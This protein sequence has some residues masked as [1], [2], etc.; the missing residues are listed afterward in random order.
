MVNEQGTTLL[1]HVRRLMSQQEALQLSDHALLER[2][3]TDRDEAAFRALVERHGPMVLRVCR[4]VLHDA[5]AAED[6]FQTTFLV[7]VRRAAS[8]STRDLLPNWLFGVAYRVAR[9]VR[10]EAAKR[11]GHAAPLERRDSAEPPSE[12]AARE[13]CAI[14]DEE[15]HRLPGRYRAAFLLCYVEGRTRDQAACQLG[16][17]VRS[18]HRQLERG[19]NLLRARLTRRGVTLSAALLAQALARGTTAAPVQS[20]LASTTVRAALAA[21]AGASAPAAADLTPVVEGVLAAMPAVKAKA[22]KVFLLAL[23]VLAAGVSWLVRPGSPAGHPQG[24]REAGGLALERWKPAG[25]VPPQADRHGDPLPPG[26]LAR[27]GTA[28]FRQGSP[29]SALSLS[30]DGKLLASVGGYATVHLWDAATGREVRHFAA[31]GRA[32]PLH[33]VTFA[34]GGRTLAACGEFGAALW[35]VATGRLVHPLGAR[36]AA[37]VA[38]SPDGAVVATGGGAG[39]VDLWDAAKGKH[40]GSLQGHQTLG[41]RLGVKALA[42]SP[43]GR[44]LA[45]G[46]HDRQIILWDVAARRQRRGFRGHGRAVTCVAFSLDGKVLSS[47]GEDRTICLWD[48]A[49]GTAL[50]RLKGHQGAVRSLAFAPGGKLLA[51]ASGDF[52]GKREDGAL[53]V[54]DVGTGREVGRPRV[55]PGGVA[56]VAFT[57]DGRTLISACGP[58]IRLWDVVTGQ[59]LNPSRGHRQGIHAVAFSPGGKV[60]ATGGMDGTIRVWHAATGAEQRE[61][62]VGRNAAVDALAFA[63]GGKVLASGSRDGAI[64][65]WDPASGAELKCLVGH[66][67]E[68]T[69]A[70]A[71]DGKVLA[72]GGRGGTILLWDAATGKEIRQLEGAEERVKSLAFSPDGKM[73]ASA[74]LRESFGEGAASDLP[75][76]LWDVATGRE[77]RRLRGH[78]GVYVTAVAFSPDGR[79]LASAGWDRTIR[80]W[81]VVSGKELYRFQDNRVPVNALAFSRDG[82]SLASCGIGDVCLWEVATGQPRRR[83]KGHYGGATSLA[84]SPDGR[85]L[86]S[87]S[88]DT[89]AL[90]WRV[91]DVPAGGAGKTGDP[92]PGDLE[93]LWAALGD[94]DAAHAYEAVRAL[95]ACS[96]K[97]V[98]FLAQRLRPISTPPRQVGELI[99]TLGHDRFAAREQAMAELEALGR[100][101]EAA[102]RAALAKP[103]AP[104]VRRRLQQ[105]LERLSGPPGKPTTLQPLRAIEV[106]EHV[107]TAGAV[108]VLEALAGGAPEAR[109]TREARASLRRLTEGP[110]SLR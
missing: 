109:I 17:S 4:G 55:R 15:L 65:L 56:A 102:A 85:L 33:G 42:F 98:P 73:L 3:I 23:A 63:P 19:R 61:L 46:G 76:R 36:M 26:V 79:R 104:E 93:R 35:D 86:A 82:R 41:R 71:P 51:S 88:G 103:A 100:Q 2:F 50:R 106:L 72:S 64:R 95:V 48:V 62:V 14:L 11:Q 7:L 89:T 44:L 92:A 21:T 6:A 20:L 47:G 70:F 68:V 81:G 52:E 60:V 74:G 24:K 39:A 29:I 30:P 43:D 13:L 77:L 97:A 31:P 37:C 53:R 22:L 84:F 87:G 40:L 91:P 69:V 80:L 9:R 96:D 75:V 57:P 34:P 27:L 38:F 110:R 5:H 54:W 59:E 32:A 105:L 10:S 83:L 18:L 1:R 66:E 45:S 8:I 16:W 107:G 108:R 78:E 101:A 25:G 28:R 94:G 67:G 90:V 58:S 12:A 49:T 99:A